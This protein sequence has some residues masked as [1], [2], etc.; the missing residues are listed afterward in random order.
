M[1]DV[2]YK[3]AEQLDVKKDIE[4]SNVVTKPSK[5]TDKKEKKQSGGGCC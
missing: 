5:L 4:D 1:Q 2:F 3:I